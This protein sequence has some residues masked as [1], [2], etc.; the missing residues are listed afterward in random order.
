MVGKKEKYLVAAQKFVERGQLDKALIEFAKVVEED[1]KDT[2][3]WLKL[4]E[5]HAKR[6]GNAEAT[7]IYLRTGELYTEQGF[8][9]KAVAVYKNVLKLSPGTVAAHLKL[10]DLFKELG[11]MSDAVQQ[12]E[13]ASGA[14]Q[15]AGKA[16][17]AVAPLRQAIEVQPDNVVLRVKLA[18]S[19]SH[20]GLTDEA[21]REFDKAAEQLKAQ[22]RADESLRVVER[23]LFHQPENFAKARELA[24][25]YI[26]R[27]SPR[28]ALPRLQACLN[29]DPREPRTLSLLAR[30]LEQLGQVPKAVSVLKEMVKLCDELGRTAERDAAVLRGL[31]LDPSDRDLGAVAA[32]HHL[33]ATAGGGGDATPPP[34]TATLT[35]ISTSAPQKPDTG[36]SFDLS[37]AVRVPT[38]GASGRVIAPVGA[39]DSGPGIGIDLGAASFDANPDIN[40]IMAE[41]DVFVKYGILERAVDHLARVFEFD[42]AHQG[43]REKLIEVL[44][45]LGR[46]ADAAYHTE[47]LSRQSARLA[48]AAMTATPPP[49]SATPASTTA[50]PQFRNGGHVSRAPEARSAPVLEPLRSMDL[51]VDDDPAAEMLTPPPALSPLRPRTEIAVSSADVVLDVDSRDESISGHFRLDDSFSASFD[52]AFDGAPTP[53]PLAD[54]TP[55]VVAAPWGLMDVDGN[56]V[57]VEDPTHAFSDEAATI[58]APPEVI[59]TVIASADAGAAAE[60]ID[61][62][63]DDELAADLE[64]VAFFMDQDMVDES[65]ALLSDLEVR[66][67]GNPRVAT[68]RRELGTVAIPLGDL[69][70]EVVKRTDYGQRPSGG[71]TVVIEGHVDGATPPP[72]AIFG[73]GTKG[74]PSTHAD[75]AVAYKEMGLHDAAIGELKL[76][77]ADHEREVFA[78][79]MMGECFEAKGTFTEAVIRY[80]RAL[81]CAQITREETIVLYYLLAGAFERLGDVSEALYFYETVSK[82]QAQYR[83]VE[84]K[85]A[86]LKPRMAKRAR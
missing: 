53:V 17:E 82:R 64:Q 44:R 81:N 57:D 7:E 2:R 31:T 35:A 58:A 43:A 18:E 75:L 55:V 23:M 71:A 41:A 30:A 76:L 72:R 8:A 74:D 59:A 21:V 3:T 47:I 79:T 68:K 1:P 34:S 25:A 49:I 54:R 11:L 66:F 69:D 73:A 10:G 45:R 39:A 36:G 70:R 42:P 26:V 5:L 65:D 67:P 38:G 32:R 9:Q 77:V 83:D 78:L 33:R 15:R 12:F 62:V 40:R 19:A 84:Q 14:L 56:D 63:D 16:P 28:L 85:I 61:D 29:G 20:A 86:E 37:G 6:G 48:Q 13:L 50:P 60:I 24:E 4:A 46:T 27:G 51:D 80:K 52:D 22:G